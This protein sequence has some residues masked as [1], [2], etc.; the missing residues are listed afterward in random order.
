M[1]T[2]RKLHWHWHQS[3]F[4]K[5]LDWCSGW[6]REREWT[7]ECERERG[8]RRRERWEWL[9]CGRKSAEVR[10]KTEAEVRKPDVRCFR[11][12][13]KNS[14]PDIDKKQTDADL[15]SKRTSTKSAATQSMGVSSK[16]MFKKLPTRT[17]SSP[18]IKNPK[19]ALTSSLLTHRLNH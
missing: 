1:Y 6:V 19:H 18:A 12:I 4:P 16:K 13:G 10:E 3:H 17:C 9:L 2:R 15:W 8:G 5:K 11:R 7:R 14:G